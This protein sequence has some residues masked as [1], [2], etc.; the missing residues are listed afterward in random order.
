MLDAEVFCAMFLCREPEPRGLRR[1]HFISDK[2]ALSD[3]RWF[4]RVWFGHK[5]PRFPAILVLQKTIGVVRTI[6]YARAVRNRY[7]EHL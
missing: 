6:R 3:K 2:C 7:V 1:E 5:C 4:R